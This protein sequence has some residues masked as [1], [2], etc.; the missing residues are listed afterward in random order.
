MML[1]FVDVAYRGH[2][3]RAAC[4]LVDSWEAG[5]PLASYVDDIATVAP[6]EAGSFFRRELPCLLSVL[7]LLPERP[8]LVVVDGYVWLPSPLRPGLGA[9]LHEALGQTTPVVGIAKTA[10]A[11][12]DRCAAVVPVFRG[13]SR[14]PLYVTAAGIDTGAAAQCVRQ[15][16][17]KHRIPEI[18]RVTDQLSRGVAGL[19]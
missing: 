19:R 9:H 12:V 4:V 6:Y 5:A 15:M 8:D 11:G 10:F 18:L 1:A 2:G 16:A 7:R 13:T 17:G 14:K 3:A